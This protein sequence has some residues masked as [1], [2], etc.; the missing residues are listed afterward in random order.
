M[1]L[2]LFH[3]DYC[4]K[5]PWQSSSDFSAAM[6]LV[7]GAFLFDFHPSLYI[8]ISTVTGL[9]ADRKPF[10]RLSQDHPSVRTLR[11]E[12]VPPIFL[13]AQIIIDNR[14]AV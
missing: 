13:H 8:L 6:K 2:L 12:P 4:G 10:H 11:N 3:D 14:T 9:I 7:L 1:L 5:S